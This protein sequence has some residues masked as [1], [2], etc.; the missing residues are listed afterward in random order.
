MAVPGFSVNDLIQ[1]IAKVKDVYD[2]FFDEYS[3]APRQLRELRD[4]LQRLQDELFGLKQIEQETGRSYT[5]RD[6][7]QRTLNECEA[8]VKNHKNALSRSRGVVRRG[9]NARGIL[10]TGLFAFEQENFE[11]L[12]DHLNR[13]RIELIGYYVLLLLQKSLNPAQAQSPILVRRTSALSISS[14]QSRSSIDPNALRDCIVE[15][16]SIGNAFNRVGGGGDTAL[17]DRLESTITRLSDLT[18]LPTGLLPQVPVAEFTRRSHQSLWQTVLETG[19]GAPSRYA[20]ARRSETVSRTCDVSI[21]RGRQTIEAAHYTMISD[22]LHRYCYFFDREGAQVMAHHLPRN[23]HPYTY[24]SR[25]NRPLLV[26]FKCIARVLP[27]LPIDESEEGQ[28]VYQF[29]RPEDFVAFQSDARNRDLTGTFDVAGISCPVPNNCHAQNVQLK[30]WRSRRDTS[31]T[32]FSFRAR[33]QIMK[34]LDFRLRHLRISTTQPPSQVC[35]LDFVKEGGRRRQS[36]TQGSVV[37]DSTSGSQRAFDASEYVRLM[38]YIKLEFASTDACTEFVNAFRLAH[39]EASRS[40]SIRT[41]STNASSAS[42]WTWSSSPTSEWLRTIPSRTSTAATSPMS[43]EHSLRRSSNLSTG[44]ASHL[45]PS[46]VGSTATGL[47]G[48]T[49]V[50]TDEERPEATFTSPEAQAEA[51]ARQDS[52]MSNGDSRV[53]P[54]DL[55]RR[56]GG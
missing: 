3:N 51:G 45:P 14:T 53:T 33:N 42:H 9:D 55:F 2:A 38:Q 50:V 24:H 10:E 26:A 43:P 34:D 28:P 32:S 13:R 49:A 1:A 6:A 29:R 8:F 7:L 5:G 44:Q 36:S 16:R 11:R 52:P 39:Y 35:R 37:S 18:G 25:F 4:E 31:S 30:F 56:A 19:A 54:L 46:S 40:P 22:T 15:L 21:R 47:V 20:S 12:L 27:P 41:V 48:I 23:C 17:D